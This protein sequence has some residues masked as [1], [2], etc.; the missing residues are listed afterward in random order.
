MDRMW[1]QDIK[2]L[3]PGLRIVHAEIATTT[4]GTLAS[5]YVKQW[6]IKLTKTGGQTGRYTINLL[7]SDGNNANAV[8]LVN[9]LATL[10]G[11]DTAAYANSKG[12]IGFI[13]ADD[14]SRN[15]NDGTFELQ[16]VISTATGQAD[17]E[18]ADGTVMKVTLWL[19]DSSASG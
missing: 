15:N 17:T 1:K 12:I 11:P 19:A 4:S 5:T 18:L 2:T 8:Y 14:V 10:I 16:W 9:A 3:I 7:K 13:R 6:G